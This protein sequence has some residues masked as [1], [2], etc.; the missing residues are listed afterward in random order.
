MI[1]DEYIERVVA[2]WPPFTDQQRDKLRVLLAPASR[3]AAT[4]GRS[5]KR[6]IGQRRESAA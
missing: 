2:D 1:T 5:N 3:P 4:T 6:K